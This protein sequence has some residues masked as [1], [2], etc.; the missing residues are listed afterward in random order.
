[1]NATTTQAVPASQQL[2]RPPSPD[3]LDSMLQVVPSTSWLTLSVLG[4]TLAGALVWSIVATAP[5]TAKAD[6][7]LLTPSGVADVAAPASGRLVDIAV[8][9]GDRVRAG[10]VVATLAQSDLD[11]QLAGR[12]L[13][14]GKLDDQQRRIRAFLQTEAGA[15]ARVDAEQNTML[16]ARVASLTEQ[17]RTLRDMVAANERLASQGFVSQERLLQVRN[18]LQ[19]VRSDRAEAATAITRLRSEND[20]HATRS[21]RELLDLDNRRSALEREIGAAK[22]E[23][24]R[25]TEVLAPSDGLVAE[26][27]ANPGEIVGMGAPVMRMLPGAADQTG[28]VGLIYLPPG[29]GKQVRVGMSVQV[30]PSTVRVQRDGYIFGEVTNVSTI[31]ATRESMMRVL[32]NS[33]LVEQLTRSGA[34]QEITVRLMPDA[35]T[36][37]GMRWSSGTGPAQPVG[38]GTT[39]EAKI[40]TSEIPLIALVFP[41]AERILARIGL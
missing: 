31:P 37:T 3:Q 13:E 5:V 14:L 15:R 35:A 16:Q 11:A 27:A 40:V 6:G 33:A 38:N 1:M 22:E 7:I 21:A 24:G 26:L 39:A 10:Q 30:I 19:Q 9:P 18:Q 34:P 36:P 29:A 41:Q 12:R 4:L 17:E 2:I 23:L 20:T 25:K 8:R 28:L 32:K